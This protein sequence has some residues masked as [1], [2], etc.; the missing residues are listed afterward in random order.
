MPN[1]YLRYLQGSGMGFCNAF[2]AMSGAPGTQEFSMAKELRLRILVNG[3]V[4]AESNGLQQGVESFRV[5]G[6]ILLPPGDHAVEAMFSG[7]AAGDED[8]IETSSGP[9]PSVN[10][11]LYHVV[12]M[13]LFALARYR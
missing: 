10:I 6:S 13:Q 5:F 8:P 1:P 3:T 9:G 11:M 7:P 2:A 4:V 12:N